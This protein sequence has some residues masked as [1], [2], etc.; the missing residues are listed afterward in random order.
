MIL[1]TI[2]D[3]PEYFVSNT[4]LVYG[5]GHR[6]LTQ[7]KI[8]KGYLRVALYRKNGSKRQALVSRLVLEAFIGPPPSP[9]HHAAHK[10]GINTDNRLSN[11]K[12]ASP[13]ENIADKKLHGKD[14]PGEKNSQA[15][16]TDEAVRII[17]REYTRVH[18]TKSNSR[19]LAARFGV[20]IDTIQNVIRGKQWTHV[21]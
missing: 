6:L 20:S 11:L 2:S 14:T 8:R 19:E 5:P 12:W 4:G 17:R 18:R 1:K 9:K 15:K 3:C 10:N 13:K 16:L 21:K 7:S